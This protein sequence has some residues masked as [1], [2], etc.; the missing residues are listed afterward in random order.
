MHMCVLYSGAGMHMCLLF[1]VI[2]NVCGTWFRSFHVLYMYWESYLLVSRLI[3]RSV[4]R[5]LK[6]GHDSANP[7]SD[8]ER[9]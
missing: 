4:D 7:M 2:L 5:P 3:L 8:R 1:F 6:H 9:L